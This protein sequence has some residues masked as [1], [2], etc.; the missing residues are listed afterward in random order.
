MGGPED[1]LAN[2]R[3]LFRPNHPVS[4]HLLIGRDGEI[5]QM[6]PFGGSAYHAGQ[7]AWNGLTGLNRW[8]IGIEL[9]NRGQVDGD[10]VID[11][12]QGPDGMWYQGYTDV[13]MQTL[14]GVIR[15]L[16]LAYPDITETVGH[17]DVSPRRKGDPG[18]LIDRTQLT[19][20]SLL[21]E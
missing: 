8:S 13:Q 9:V 21:A 2:L 1:F 10:H 17:S 3:A 20:A 7:S 5:V 19:R 11:A 4:A 6:R 15:A 12:R 14:R 18:P 16:Y